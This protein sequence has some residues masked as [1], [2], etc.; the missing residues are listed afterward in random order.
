MYEI[1][2]NNIN[3]SSP[4]ERS[5]LFNHERKGSRLS[6]FVISGETKI[7]NINPFKKPNEE[8]GHTNSIY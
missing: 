2:S 8:T 7:Q 6:N 4:R 5:K 3:P 1:L